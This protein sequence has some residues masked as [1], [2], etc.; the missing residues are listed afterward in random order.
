MTSGPSP[1]QPTPPGW[2]AD[3]WAPG[4]L[5]YWDGIGWTSHL[6]SAPVDRPQTNTLGIVGLLL[7]VLFPLAGFI[8]GII[9]V[10]KDRTWWGAGCIFVSMAFA[11]LLPILIGALG[12]W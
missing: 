9:L 7:S 4:A 8:I 12:W 3:P 10:A 2:Y 1:A 6:A 11:M 5:R